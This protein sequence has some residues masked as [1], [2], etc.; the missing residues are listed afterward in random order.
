M[1]FDPDL[2][3]Q[4]QV[5]KG[6]ASAAKAGFNPDVYLKTNRGGNIITS[7]VP[8]LVGEVPNPP[9]VQ[10]PP[11]TMMD[12][13]KA[14]YEVPAAI[15]SGAAAP[16]LGIGAG[17]IENIQKGT[18]KRLDS[19]E[20]GQRFQY[21][22]TSPV[23]QDILQSMGS[24]LEASKLPPVIPSVG[25]LPSYARAAGGTPTQVRQAAQ[26]VQ[27]TGPRIAQALRQVAPPPAPASTMSG[28]GAAQ[29]P[30]AITRMQMAQQLRV[31][32]PLTKGQATKELGQQQFEAETMKTYPEGVGRPII[33]RKIDQNQRILS[34]FDA[35]LEPIGSKTAAPDNL[36]EVGKVVDSALV[37][38]AKAAKKEISNAYKLADESGQTQELI[39]VNSIKTFLDG[40]EAEAINAPIITSAKM[41]LDTLAPNGDISI[42]QL[43]E[44]RKM[45]GRLSGSTPTNAEFGREIN[46]LIDAS[47]EGK[48]GNLYQDARKLRANYA[49]EFENVGVVDKLLSKKAGTTDRA[50]AFEKVF[51]HAI[52]NGSL[53]DVKAIGQTL[54][55]AGPEGQQAYREL[56]GQTIEYMREAITK[57]IRTDESG[58]RIVSAAQ[59]DTVVKN[60]DKSGKLDYLF[61]KKGAEEIRNLR[62]TAILVYDM[63]LGVNTSNT[64]SAMDKVFNRLLQKIPLAGPMVEVGS[65]A[66]EKQKLTKKVQ[67]SLNYTPEKI[68]DELRKGKK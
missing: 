5:T 19:P 47:T 18:N 9:V 16:F 8:T 14:L 21:Q 53:D 10:G 64:S 40:L 25:M 57:N 6:N 28:V 49:R 62:D 52:L 2:Y 63:P 27:E 22:P 4:E 23:S 61:G 45:V 38:K 35:F 13:V 67:E 51:D 44:V 24:A 60:L 43:E 15:V 31:P 50:V 54:K 12:R 42:N 1:S 58:K 65:E 39:N 11:V 30:E 26:T 33:D 3:L 48:G 36:Y 41:K 37:N 29:S 56:V 68:A 20:F 59:F 17:A 34:N 46:K 55:R 7:D 32:V 66:I